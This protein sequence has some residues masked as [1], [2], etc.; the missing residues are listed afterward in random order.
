[1]LN[2]THFLTLVKEADMFAL[3]RPGPY[4]CAEYEFGGFPAWLL[5]DPNMK[6][7]S[8]Y[9]PYIEA[10]DRYWKEL[11]T[12]VKKFQFTTNGGPIIAVQ[13][14]NEFGSYGNTNN[15]ADRNYMKALEGMALK[16]GIKELIY[17]CDGPEQHGTLPGIILQSYTH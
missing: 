11:L 17:T 8:D 4:I 15:P 10:V 7:R 14:E 12:V 2:L 16:Y 3:F 9:K 1:M 13:M 5:R 6:L